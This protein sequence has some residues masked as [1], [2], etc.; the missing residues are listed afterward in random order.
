MKYLAIFF[1]ILAA[2]SSPLVQGEGPADETR[3][4]LRSEFL[5]MINRDRAGMG[6]PPVQLDPQASAVADT[7]CKAQIKNGTTGHFTTDGL[8]PYMRYSFAGGNDGVSKNAAAWSAAYKFSDRSLYDMIRRSEDAMMHEPPGHDG[9]RR[10]LL[11]PYATHVGIGLAWDGG[12][13]RLTQEFI[14]RYVE[15]KRPLPRAAGVGDQVLGRGKAMPGYRIEAISIHHEPLPR[16]L[17]VQ[18]ANLIDSYSLPDK[19]RDYLPRL[20]GTY[21]QRH[22]DGALY[23]VR[24]EYADGRRGDFSVSRDGTFSFD[25]PFTDGPGIY[26]VVVWVRAN[27]NDKMTPIAASNVSI[28]VERPAGDFTFAG[29]GTR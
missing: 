16:P 26:T 13:F 5:H 25:V 7:Y 21:F 29:A 22:P 3:I 19:R 8:A 20:R 15:W 6:L 18:A 28:R 24:E 2:A 11:D 23:E 10:T 14:R 17:A 27:G 9:H 1:A 12:E 4:A